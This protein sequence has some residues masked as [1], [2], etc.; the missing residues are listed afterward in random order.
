[1]IE[2]S[3]QYKSENEYII[4]EEPKKISPQ[5]RGSKLTELDEIGN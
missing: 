3:D 4:A 5:K 1:M 2:L